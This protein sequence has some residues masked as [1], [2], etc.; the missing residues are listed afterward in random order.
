[1]PLMTNELFARE[2]ERERE[3]ERKRRCGGRSAPWCA[4]CAPHDKELFARI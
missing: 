3:S 2:R 1:V 4:P